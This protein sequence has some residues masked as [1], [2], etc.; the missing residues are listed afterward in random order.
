MKRIFALMLALVLVLSLF[1]ACGG[2][3]AATNQPAA[4]SGNAAAP[5]APKEINIAKAYDATT[6]DPH[7]GNDDGS[8]NIIKYL[9]EGLVR[10]KGGII[11]PG[12]AERWEVSEDGLEV[13]F[14]LRDNAVWTDGTPVTAEDFHYSFLRLL[15]PTVGYNYSD[16]GFIFK[17]GEAYFN[18]E[19]TAEEVGVEVID[20]KTLK[21]TR[22]NPS[23]ETLYELASTPFLPIRKDVAEAHGV[24]YGAEADKIMTNGAFTLTEWAHESKLVLVKNDTYW[25]KDSIKLDKMTFVVGASGDTAIDMMMAGQLDLLE[26]G[27]DSKIAPLTDM[28]YVAVPYSAGYQCLHMN[29]KGR[30]ADTAKFMS[31]TNFRRALNLT[32]NRAAIIASAN[33]GLMPATRISSS[34]DMGV[35]DTMHNEYPLEAWPATGDAA[36]AKEYFDLAMQELGTTAA[37]VPELSMLC[38]D[39][40]GNMTILQAAQDMLLNTLGIKCVIDP[41]PI[42]QMI[43]KAI[44]GDWDF[45]YGGM[46]AGTM[47]WLSAGSVAEGFYSDPAKDSFGT[48]NYCNEEFNALYNQASVTMD[49]KERKNLLFQMEKILVDDPATIILGWNRTYVVTKAGLTGLLISGSDSDYTYMDL[50]Q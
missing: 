25:D 32:I 31:N 37:D 13:I 24:A 7:Q 50:A 5:A 33:L 12:V 36:K 10:N 20:A 11:V 1:A 39:S 28:G 23:L 8:Y 4:D 16:S 22:E 44:G 42:Q 35:A 26:N 17:N 30:N 19:A 18:G 3:N 46:T 21:I 43:G 2:Q 47:D 41:Q 49:V 48:Y 9:S 27:V 38:F 14:Y 45:W 29:S 15:D 6:L 34:T 40:E